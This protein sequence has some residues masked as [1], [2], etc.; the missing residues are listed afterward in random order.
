VTEPL[1]FAR[2]CDYYTELGPSGTATSTARLVF[3]VDEDG[4]GRIYDEPPW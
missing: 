1:Q 2:A 4:Q 3:D